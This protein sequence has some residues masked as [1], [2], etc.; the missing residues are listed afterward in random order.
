MI[1]HQRSHRSD[2]PPH[3]KPRTPPVVTEAEGGSLE[4]C[5]HVLAMFSLGSGPVP[6]RYLQC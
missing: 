4:R 5:K 6:D 1:P 2:G 3:S